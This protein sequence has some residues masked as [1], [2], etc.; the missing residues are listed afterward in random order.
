MKTPNE[1]V[2]KVGALRKEVTYLNNIKSEQMK[3]HYSRRDYGLLDF[4]NK[5]ISRHRSIIEELE[6]ALL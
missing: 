1:I 3:I 2:K 4:V 5:E 6:W